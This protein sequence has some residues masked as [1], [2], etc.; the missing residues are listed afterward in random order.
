MSLFVNAVRKG[1]FCAGHLLRKMG[2]DRNASSIRKAF[3]VLGA[4]TARLE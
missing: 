1:R 3:D 2:V 4:L